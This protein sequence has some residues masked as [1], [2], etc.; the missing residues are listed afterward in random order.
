VLRCLAEVHWCFA[1]TYCLHFQSRRIHQARK[2]CSVLGLL[3]GPKMEAVF[4]SKISI[5]VYHTTRCLIA[6]YRT[7]H[8]Q[9][10][11][12]IKSHILAVVQK[13]LNENQLLKFIQAYVLKDVIYIRLLL[14][15]GSCLKLC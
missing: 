6:E 4:F 1:G 13:P 5:N 11:K 7:L 10:R 8:G 3:F 15:G 14:R 9:R 2:A 12:N